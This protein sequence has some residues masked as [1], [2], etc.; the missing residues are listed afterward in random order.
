MIVPSKD[1]RPGGTPMN[2]FFS[3]AR[4]NLAAQHRAQVR[5]E[6]DE[7]RVAKLCASGTRRPARR[8]GS[9]LARVAHLPF[10]GR[11]SDARRT[12]AVLHGA[13]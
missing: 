3:T 2:S 8:L 1:D 12:E 4:T 5:H 7:A 11:R 10:A 13:S 6:V 9:A